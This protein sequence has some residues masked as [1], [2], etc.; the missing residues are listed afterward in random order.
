[1]IVASDDFSCLVDEY[2]DFHEASMNNNHERVVNEICESR[3]PSS[4]SEPSDVHTPQPT[5]NPSQNPTPSP[6]PNATPN[7][8][9]YPTPSPTNYH[10][11]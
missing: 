5:P 8:T 11:A 7:P 4:T 10:C 2:N 1:M 6:T 3:T 9:P